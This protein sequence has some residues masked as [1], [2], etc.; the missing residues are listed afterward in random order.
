MRFIELLE[1]KVESSWIKDISYNK[2]NQTATMILLN[3]N[4]YSVQFLEKEVFDGWF[5]APSKGKYFQ[6]VIRGFYP[7]TKL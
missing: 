7:V 4:T 6:E 3:G 1:D 2:P 5:N